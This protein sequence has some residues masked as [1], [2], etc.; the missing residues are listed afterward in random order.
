MSDVIGIDKELYRNVFRLVE[1]RFSVI[2]YSGPIGYIDFQILADIR[3]FLNIPIRAVED[4]DPEVGKIDIIHLVPVLLEARRC[5][6]IGSLIQQR[7]VLV[8]ALDVRLVGRIDG[9]EV[10]G[11]IQ[12]D[13]SELDFGG[14]CGIGQKPQFVGLA[15]FG[16]VED[17]IRSIGKYLE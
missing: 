6:C 8:Q 15:E 11:E 17:M 14:Q 3:G 16:E 4:I 7:I 13:F 2:A 10:I 5:C 1:N 12:R 9:R